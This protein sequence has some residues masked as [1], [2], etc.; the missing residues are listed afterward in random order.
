MLNRFFLL[1]KKKLFHLNRSITGKDT[2]LTLDIIK[3]NLKNLKIRKVKSNTKVFDWKIPDEWNVESAYVLDK[4]KKKIIDF[5]NNNLHL[6]GYSKKIKKKISKKN[7]L[8]KIYT[9]SS[10]PNA[11]PYK[12]SYYKRDWGF[13][14]SHNQKKKNNKK[15]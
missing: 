9:L 14:I 5:K 8:K 4:S 11:I 2:K 1:A 7:L 3:K 10:L 12:T 15:L 13:C 6:V